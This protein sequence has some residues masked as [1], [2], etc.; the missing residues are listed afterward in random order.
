MLMASSRA[1]GQRGTLISGGISGA[2]ATPTQASRSSMELIISPPRAMCTRV[3]YRTHARAKDIACGRVTR[4]RKICYAG[5]GMTRAPDTSRVRA[6]DI[7][8]GAGGSMQRWMILLGWMYPTTPPCSTRA[9]PV[10]RP[11]GERPPDQ[12]SRN[13]NGSPFRMVWYSGEIH[14][15]TLRPADTLMR[16]AQVE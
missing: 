2:R 11:A 1:A 15:G 8:Y 10:V 6:K 9:H 5:M 4:E 14:V 7:S 13:M 12:M 3:R 16:R